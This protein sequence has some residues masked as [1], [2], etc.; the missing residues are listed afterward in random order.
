MSLKD[1]RDCYE[2]TWSIGERIFGND[3]KRREKMFD[4]LVDSVA[5][6]T[7]T[8]CFILNVAAEYLL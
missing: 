1:L 4:A 3:F 6:Y 2:K 5:L 7:Y 8:G